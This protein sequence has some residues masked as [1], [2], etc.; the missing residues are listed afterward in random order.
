MTFYRTL[1]LSDLHIG[2]TY[3]PSQE[4]AYKITTDIAHNGLEGIRSVLVTGDIFHGPADLNPAL[5]REAAE[6]FKT[7]MQELNED[8]QAAPLGPEDFLFVPGNHDIL[9]RD[10]PGDRWE[11]YRLFL[12]EFYGT[13]PDW[14]DPED[15]SFC[16]PYPDDKLVF[17]GFNSCGLEKKRLY[18]QGVACCQA[19]E[20]EKYRGAGIDKGALMKLLESENPEQFEDFGEISMRQLSKQRRNMARL[21][22]FQAVAMF[23]HHFF[24]FP[25][26]ASSLGDA[27]VVRN[28][29]TVVRDLRFMGVKTILHGHKHFDLERPFINDDYYETTDSIIN[30]FAGGSAGAARGLQR[31]TFSIIDFYPEHENVQ[32]RQQ[33]FVYKEDALDPIKTIHIPPISK[34]AQ[35]VKLLELL[36]NWNTAAHEAYLSAVMS[37]VHFHR[38]CIAAAE[39]AGNSLAGYADTCRCLERDNRHL[40]C[41][42]YGIARRAYA[43]IVQRSPEQT[44]ALSV[45]RERLD[46]FFKDWIEPGV[47]DGYQDL[48]DASKLDQAA[49]RCAGLLD[50]AG[51]HRRRQ[52]LAFTM[53]GIFFTDLNLVL[54][55]YADDFY[56]QINHKVNI[57][58][59]PNHFH[60]HVPA[61]RIQLQ[62]DPDR[63]SAYIKLWCN[64]ATA[65]KMAV[66][67]VKEFDLSLN[68]LEDFF[69]LIGLKLYYLLPQIEKDA[70][71]DALDNYNFEAYIPSLLPLL[72]GDN[73]Y[74]SKEVFARELIQNAIDAISVRE[75]VEGRLS[76]EDRV[77]RIFL[78][79]G[80]ENRSIFRITDRGTGMDRY[81]VER[82]FTSIGRSFYSG[83][84]Y[85]ELNIGYRPISSFGIGF[86]SSF[87]VCREIDVHTRSFQGEQEGLKL[88][89]P[90]YEGCFFIERTGER[91]VGTE[92]TLYL[93]PAYDSS[94]IPGYIRR[95]M[96]DIKYDIEIRR[97]NQPAIRVPAHSVRRKDRHQFASLFVP[98]LE[99]GTAGRLDWEQEVFSGKFTAENDYGLL[100]NLGCR[101]GTDESAILNAGIVTSYRPQM[102]GLIS[103]GLSD[104]LSRNRQ[105]PID[106]RHKRMYN[107]FIFNFPSDWIKL[108]VSREKV[109][110][111]SDQMQ[112]LHRETGAARYLQAA[113]SLALKE[114]IESL[115][116]CCKEGRLDLPAANIAELLDFLWSLNGVRDAALQQWWRE[117]M[118][119]VRI[120]FTE[121]GILYTLCHE[122]NQQRPISDYANHEARKQVQA[123]FNKLAPHGSP[124]EHFISA[125][126]N[127]ILAINIEKLMYDFE[128]QMREWEEHSANPPALDNVQCASLGLHT[129]LVEHYMH[130]AGIPPQKS[131][132]TVFHDKIKSRYMTWHHLVRTFLSRVMTA[133]A[134]ERGEA[135]LFLRYED[136]VTHRKL[137]PIK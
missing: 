2:D 114:Q 124:R 126:G 32:L 110:S 39:W 61:P 51:D 17:L 108:D 77:I 37:N 24:L 81:K 102:Y 59:E 118:Y 67:F 28:H 117:Q 35:L 125:D 45:V 74:H 25:D 21:D 52:H 95:S 15:F 105:R 90:N 46:A 82:Y 36:E 5:I 13:I 26:I 123:L 41:L 115:L 48:F 106:T 50:K 75:A 4:L 30:V 14:Y 33:K 12:E 55:E 107:Q 119:T 53:L 18:N 71:L 113:I 120:V 129:L 43:Y 99:D 98:F 137:I 68:K 11:K 103:E 10:A 6:F 72:I 60:A 91:E 101:Y 49:K 56:R 86:L 23:H 66:L 78:G 87:M 130:E 83:D 133:G 116:R 94:G 7:L 128:C 44:G 9:W 34:S 38:I 89:I 47:P 97:Q 136:L 109:V 131:H 76:D 121:Q 58:M 54:T 22:G 104:F 134:V 132:L 111:F 62:S 85:A 127:S 42:L 63:R 57:K 70:D 122:G 27:D 40:L 19:V 100:I 20:D 3:L 80:P 88:H 8:S 73:I 1:H 16:R 79:Q 69:K 64:D 112:A 29:P 84:D 93:N 65:H 92:I 96:K 31:H 135:E